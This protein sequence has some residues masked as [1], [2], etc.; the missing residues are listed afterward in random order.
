MHRGMFNVILMKEAVNMQ[1]D[2]K[3][4]KVEGSRPDEVNEWFQFT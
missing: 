3:S 4:R 2:C 1:R